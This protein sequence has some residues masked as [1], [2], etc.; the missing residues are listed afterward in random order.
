MSCFFTFTI[1]N[2][3]FHQ[4]FHSHNTK[5]HSHNTKVHGHNTNVHN[6]KVPR[7]KGFTVTIPTFTIARFK[8]F[9]VTISRRRDGA[10]SFTVPA[11]ARASHP[12]PAEI[13]RLA[14]RGAELPSYADFSRT[15]A[16]R[17]RGRFWPPQAGPGE[18]KVK[19]NTG[20]GS[21]ERSRAHGP[22]YQ[23]RPKY[24]MCCSLGL[25]SAPNLRPPLAQ[26]RLGELQFC[27][28]FGA[29]SAFAVSDTVAVLC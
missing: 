3:Q 20:L 4:S 17:R 16:A 25:R 14:P 10:R 28:P 29:A 26:L 21:R 13:A 24:Q 5:V 6:T 7:F 15:L 2:H 22:L 23:T 1:H 11:R 27:A 12:P 8:G 9:T 19:P 18:T